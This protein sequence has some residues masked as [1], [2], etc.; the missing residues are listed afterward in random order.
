MKTVTG[1]KLIK[2]MLPFP[3]SAVNHNLIMLLR[4]KPFN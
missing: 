3:N 2:K 4:P 1:K